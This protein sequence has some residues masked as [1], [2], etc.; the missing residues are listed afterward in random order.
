MGHTGNSTRG[1]DVSV[2]WSISVPN[3]PGF[4]TNPSR[5]HVIEE[6]ADNLGQLKSRQ[7]DSHAEVSK[8]SGPIRSWVAGA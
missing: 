5:T 4:H 2:L 3:S 1:I 7:P 6:C 8:T